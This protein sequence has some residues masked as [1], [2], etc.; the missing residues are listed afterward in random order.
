MNAVS[1][2]LRAI[3][4]ELATTAKQNL[5]KLQEG[6]TV[7]QERLKDGVYTR[8]TSFGNFHQFDFRTKTNGDIGKQIKPCG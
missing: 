4:V 2:V 5:P 7:V 1:S 3:A 8:E 6:E